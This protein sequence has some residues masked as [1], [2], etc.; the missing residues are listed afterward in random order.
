M[1]VCQYHSSFAMCKSEV[2]LRSVDITQG[3]TEIHGDKMRLS[4]FLLSII[5]RLVM[6]PIMTMIISAMSI[7]E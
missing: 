4:G 6:I 1:L 2:C 5:S 7:K 3:F